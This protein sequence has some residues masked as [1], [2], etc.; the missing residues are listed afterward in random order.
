MKLAQ[1]ESRSNESTQG[2]TYDVIILGGALSGASTAYLLARQHPGKRILVIERSPAFSKRV[3]EATVEISTY[4]LTRVLGL[5][6]YL[7]H[8]H[9]NKQGLR[10]WFYRDSK[11]N[12]D[13]SSEI[14]PGYNARFPSYQV[15]RSK[16]DEEVLRRAQDAGVI[17]KRPAE[18]KSVDWTEGGVSTVHYSESGT[19]HQAHARWIVDASGI[20]RIM[21]RSQ[22]WVRPNNEHPIAS[23]WSR[24]RGVGC[25]DGLDFRDAHPGI[26]SRVIGT[27]FTATNHLIGKGWWS[28]WIPL[29]GDEVS[30]GIVWD[31]RLTKAADGES[32]AERL[33]NHLLQHPLAGPLL[34]SAT[35]V[36]DDVHYRKN[37]AWCSERIAAD[38]LFLVG[39]AAGFIDPFYSP[40]MDWISFS[41]SAATGLINDCWQNPQNSASMANAAND[42]F[43]LS[44]QRWFEAIY[45]DKYYYM[46]DYE[47]L[48]IAFRLDLGLYY[49]GVVSQPYKY[50]KS[51]LRNPP[52]TGP[53]TDIP[54]KIIRFYNRRLAA[55]AASRL[56]RGSW[57]RHN[58]NHAF[59]FNSYRMDYTLPIRVAF[60]FLKYARLELA[61]GWR[62]W[63][64][65]PTTAAAKSL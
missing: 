33:R 11:D 29:R 14:G 54:F 45:R 64:R 34:H 24:W 40:G 44:Y 5:T 36:D 16:L 53:H 22:K 3:G 23:I 59:A 21:A 26:A 46:G 52:F 28:W 17:L 7:N 55:I 15:D 19:L 12:A 48:N 65:S 41:V 49:L 30:I 32:P 39:D 57:G 37:L 2:D 6:E 1:E 4:F 60:A 43:R 25:I 61:E 10:F 20:A 62:S 63:G 9:L 38:G 13:T 47:L 58:L 56:Q 51:A 18:V 31:D 35:M 8:E 42:A 50:S 27:R